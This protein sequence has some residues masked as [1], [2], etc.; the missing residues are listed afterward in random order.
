MEKNKDRKAS[1]AKRSRT[2]LCFRIAI[3]GIIVGLVVCGTVIQTSAVT[4]AEMVQEQME[5]ARIPSVSVG[6]VEDQEVTH[7]SFGEPQTDQTSLYQIGSTTKAYTALGVFWL[8]DEGL[9]S[10]DDPVS[11]YLPWF[12]MNYEGQEVPEKDLTIAN[13]IYQISGFT[14]EENKYPKAETGMPLEEHIKSLIGKELVFYPSTD[15]AYANTNYNILGLLIETVSGKAYPNF[16]TETILTPLGFANTYPDPKQA[17][18][19]G[20][21]VSGTRPAFFQTLSYG[22]PIVEAAIPA[23]YIHSNAQDMS[24]WLQIQMGSIEVTPQM[25]RIIQRSHQPDSLHQVDQETRYAGGWFV[26]DDQTIYHTG[27][28]ANYSTIVIMKPEADLAVCVLT[29]TNASVNTNAIA[30]NVLAILSGQPA[31]AYQADIWVLIDTIFTVVT[32]CCVSLIIFLSVWIFRVKKQYRE[33]VRRK[34][35]AG[36][37]RSWWMGIPILLSLLT[38][39]MLIVFPLAFQIGWEAMTV[40]APYSMFTGI[41]SLGVLSGLSLVLVYVVATYPK[42]RVVF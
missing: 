28:T 4:D 26:A 3:C 32:F 12:K 16:M 40:W 34:S 18:N 20:E 30:D 33:G 29:N 31:A 38:I 37:L 15:Y 23:G 41:A 39:A 7:L 22:V 17:A 6:I 2:A 1:G 27:G 21:I 11:N 36:K 13:L 35:K 9:L 25:K 14:N 19:E 42:Q 24:R 8:E 5:K 10:L